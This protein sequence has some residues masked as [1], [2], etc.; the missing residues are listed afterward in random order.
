MAELILFHVPFKG[1]MFEHI[2][3]HVPFKGRMAE[4]QGLSAAII[5]QAAH[6]LSTRQL[7]QRGELFLRANTPKVLLS[8]KEGVDV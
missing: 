2:L 3:F 4:P 1:R 6:T 8:G 7:P 5:T